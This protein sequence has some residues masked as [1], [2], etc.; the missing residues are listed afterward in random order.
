MNATSK[1]GTLPSSCALGYEHL[2]KGKL[3]FQRMTKFMS[4]RNVRA[5]EDLRQEIS[6]R[7]LAFLLAGV[8]LAYGLSCESFTF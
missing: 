4:F 3:V 8:V 7:T 6:Q 5:W 2:E 1:G